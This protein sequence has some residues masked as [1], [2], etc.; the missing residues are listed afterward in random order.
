[1]YS[2]ALAFL[3]LWNSMYVEG[4]LLVIDTFFAAL[5]IIT[6][7]LLAWFKARND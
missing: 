7:G 4:V 5:W 6:A 2:V 1:M 3:M